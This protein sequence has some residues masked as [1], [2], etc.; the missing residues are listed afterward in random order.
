[1]FYFNEGST[2]K[3]LHQVRSAWKDI[4]Y[5]ERDSRSWAVNRN[6]SYSQWITERVK[7]VKLAFKVILPI[8]M[9]EECMVDLES[10]NIKQLKEEIAR[11]K[12][13]NVALDSNIQNLQHDYVDL[14]Q[15]YEEKIKE[16]QELMK[17]QKTQ[18]ENIS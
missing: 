16:N 14:R 6:I 3:I 8:P 15:V 10:E 1:V 7:E 4:S 9:K 13:K 12:K 2:S 18:K 5:M 11:L 17:K